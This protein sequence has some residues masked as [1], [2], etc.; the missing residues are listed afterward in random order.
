MTRPPFS[1]PACADATSD[2]PAPELG[3]VVGPCPKCGG[4]L[5]LD[6]DKQGYGT[7][8]EQCEHVVRCGYFRTL[9]RL[10]IPAHGRAS[11]TVAPDSAIDTGNTGDTVR[12]PSRNGTRRAY[13]TGTARGALKAAIPAV[14][15]AHETAALTA[16]HVAARCGRPRPTVQARLFS[17]SR[18]GAIESKKVGTG[19]TAPRLYWQRGHA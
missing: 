5:S 9:E 19:Q 17:L 14:L 11:R 10:A 16:G 8:I 4:T 18:E 12:T 3:S 13:T 7:T 15:P 6:S 1:T 2:A